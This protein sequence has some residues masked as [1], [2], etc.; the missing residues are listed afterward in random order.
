MKFEETKP[1]LKKQNTDFNIWLQLR[2]EVLP[3][4]LQEPVDQCLL[5]SIYLSINFHWA[6]E[7]LFNLT[8]T[9]MYNDQ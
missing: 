4:R 7:Y 5:P 1:K 8:H 3:A 2:D 9:G 6:M